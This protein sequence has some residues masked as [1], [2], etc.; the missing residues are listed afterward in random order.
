MTCQPVA[1]FV[2]DGRD[3]GRPLSDRQRRVLLE[4]ARHHDQRRAAA[5]MGISWYT[6]R[7]YSSLAYEKLGAESVSHA[8]ALL[9]WL[10]PPED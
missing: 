1:P 6:L 2:R 7:G 5:C 8:F 4:M 10:Q 9:G 3:F